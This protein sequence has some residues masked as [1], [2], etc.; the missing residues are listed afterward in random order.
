M[1]SIGKQSEHQ[2]S[3]EEFPITN[4]CEVSIVETAKGFHHHL[5]TAAFSAVDTFIVQHVGIDCGFTF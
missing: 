4:T 1:Y 5:L 3:K 2:T